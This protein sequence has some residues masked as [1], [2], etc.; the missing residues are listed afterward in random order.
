MTKNEDE[1]TCHRHD[2]YTAQC[3][4]CL[5]REWTFPIDKQDEL[6]PEV[7]LAADLETRCEFCGCQ[8]I[9][10][11]RVTNYCTCKRCMARREREAAEGREIQEGFFCNRASKRCKA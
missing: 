7:L 5:H 3:P 1:N 10:V 9:T 8:C 4:R 6:S 11:P 2:Y